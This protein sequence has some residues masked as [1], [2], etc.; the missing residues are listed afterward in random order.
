[1][2][3]AIVS[4]ILSCTLFITALFYPAFIGNHK[5][6]QTHGY[7]SYGEDSKIFAS[8]SQNSEI[9]E[10][11][12]YPRK[13]A[14]HYATLT[15]NYFSD[16]TKTFP[17]ART[18]SYHEPI[19]NHEKFFNDLDIMGPVFDA[20]GHEYYD[21]TFPAYWFD[22]SGIIV[23]H[24]QSTLPDGILP[25]Y[26]IHD[27]QIF[28]NG[29]RNNPYDEVWKKKGYWTDGKHYH[30]LWTVALTNK[31]WSMWWIYGFSNYIRLHSGFGY[32]VVYKFKNK[33]E[34]DECQTIPDTIGDTVP[35]SM[36][37]ANYVIAR[38]GFWNKD[39][40]KYPDAYVFTAAAQKG[41]CELEIAR[42]YRIRFKDIGCK[43]RFDDDDAPQECCYIQSEKLPCS[44]LTSNETTD[45]RHVHQI[46]AIKSGL[47]I[48][49]VCLFIPIFVWLECR[50]RQE[51]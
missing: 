15:L 21:V 39:D 51:G 37:R 14:K 8:H 40:Y 35:R 36:E 33:S 5:S 4:L 41:N 31:A 7:E 49:F 18:I 19:K 10:Y 17:A 48:A 11:E 2:K 20:D 27:P 1:M 13:E 12:D 46:L 43:L 24:W 16:P 32:I 22:Y 47:I 23:K 44:K 28:F 42:V 45:R 26:D 29:R 34:N 3:F 50:D 6:P 38:I 9:A 30:S 25:V